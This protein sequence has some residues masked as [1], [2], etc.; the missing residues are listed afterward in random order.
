[1]MNNQIKK[2]RSVFSL[3]TEVMNFNEYWKVSPEM[4]RT[5][6]TATSDQATIT[7]T[8]FDPHFRLV[9]KV[10]MKFKSGRRV[11]VTPGGVVDLPPRVE[12]VQR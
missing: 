7:I 12:I 2:A 1:M 9:K 3:T 11:A 10:V 5:T 4:G 6:Y 8:Y